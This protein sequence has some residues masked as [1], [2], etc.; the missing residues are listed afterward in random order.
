MKNKMILSYIAFL[1]LCTGQLDGESEVFGNDQEEKSNSFLDCDWGNIGDF[2][3]FDRLFR[4][5]WKLKTFYSTHELN[6]QSLILSW[7][8]STIYFVVLSSDNF[9]SNSDSIFGNEIVANDSDFLSA[10]SNLMDNAVQSIPILV[11]EHR[12]LIF[13]CFFPHSSHCDL[14]VS[15]KKQLP[16]N[17]Q[18]SCDRGPSLLLTNEISSG[19]TKQ[20][21]KVHKKNAFTYV[22]M[23]RII[24]WLLWLSTFGR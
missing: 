1:D 4:Y 19:V 23:F 18:P 6:L 13:C 7:L 2:D 12:T 14:F 20:E 15:V 24:S 3:D 21:N 22:P 5:D 9:C 8:D 10:S 11:C 16:L 17:K